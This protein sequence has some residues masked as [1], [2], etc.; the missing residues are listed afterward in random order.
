MPRYYRFAIFIA[1]AWCQGGFSQDHCQTQQSD[2]R[3]VEQLNAHVESLRTQLTDLKK[4]AQTGES[5]AIRAVEENLLTTSEQL[6]CKEEDVT[7]NSKG[8]LNTASFVQVPLLYVTDRQHSPKDGSYTA[9]ASQ[10]IEFGRVSAVIDEIGSIRTGLIRGTKRVPAPSSLGKAQIARPQPIT[11]AAFT[12][13]LA[14][15][16]GADPIRVLLFV[17]GF[18]VQYYEAALS[19]ARL[20]TSMQTPLVPIFYSWPS[21]GDVLGYWH[22]EDEVSAAVVRFTPF[23]QKLLSMP[24]VS[25]V[26]VCHSMGARIVVRAL[27]E[28]SRKGVELPGLTNVAFAAADVNVEEFRTQWPYLENLRPVQW[29]SYESSSDF[30]LHLST[31]IHSFRRV[32]ESEG[33]LFIEDRMNSIDASSTTS[34]LRSFGHSYIINSPALSAD[35]GDWVV[36]N[37]PPDV[38][39]LQRMTQG[40]AIYWSFP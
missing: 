32:G 1:L 24:N 36:Q 34:I 35:L 8:I 25:V 29:T 38:R 19:A 22:D 40:N 9:T 5:A 18:N 30:A 28:L 4:T 23:L 21:R 39:G 27:G 37:L 31:Y 12:S 14:N 7:L 15:P 2:S 11:E 13:L 26:V 16:H 20:A 6:E 10:S 3:T 17:H 33:G